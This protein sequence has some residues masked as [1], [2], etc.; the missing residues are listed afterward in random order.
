MRKV[1]RHGILAGLLANSPAPS[2]PVLKT[3]NMMAA[4]ANLREMEVEQGFTLVLRSVIIN[5]ED[6]R[7]IVASQDG[8]KIRLVLLDAMKPGHG[9]FSR[10]IAAIWRHDL[11]PVIVEPNEALISWCVRHDYRRRVIGKGKHRHEVWYPR[12][13]HT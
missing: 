13:G 6:W 10:L 7:E 1:S 5:P 3:E 4:A 8:K 2:A 9:A 12:R 11:V